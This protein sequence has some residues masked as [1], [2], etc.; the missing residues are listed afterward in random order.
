MY[1]FIFIFTATP[2]FYPIELEAEYFLNH[3][4]TMNCTATMDPNTT[5]VFLVVDYTN[6]QI[7]AFPANDE[8]TFIEP[9]NEDNCNPK[10]HVLFQLAYSD[11]ED[12][13]FWACM[14]EDVDYGKNFTS[15]FQQPKFINIQ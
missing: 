9:S 5:K 15:Q 6:N 14:V 10:V 8:K 12:T 11:W 13:K 2:N 7:S 4:A 1:V 3:P